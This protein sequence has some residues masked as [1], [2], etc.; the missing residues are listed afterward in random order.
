MVDQTKP[1]GQD[2]LEFDPLDPNSATRVA[3]RGLAGTE[4]A[5][6]PAPAPAEAPTVDR[7]SATKVVATPV[8]RPAAPPL[9]IDFA[10]VL[11]KSREAAGAHR[12]GAHALEMGEFQ[13][14]YDKQALERA[15]A[16]PKFDM[17]SALEDDERFQP[18]R[19]VDKRGSVW[20]RALL[21]VLIPAVLAVAGAFIYLSTKGGNSSEELE[22]L[23]KADEAHRN[24][25]LEHEKEMAR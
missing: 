24:R 17:P 1:D 6:L 9:K 14:K 18:L 13:S 15:Q 7:H 11:G 8:S 21:V 5:P 23:K 16:A 3:P 22:R 20:F 19:V 4:V 2:E 10:E 12:I 25:A